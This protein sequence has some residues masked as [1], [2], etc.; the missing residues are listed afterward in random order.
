MK[1]I[2]ISLL[3]IAALACFVGAWIAN[4]RLTRD[5]DRRGLEYGCKRWPHETNND[6]YQRLRA[7]IGW[8]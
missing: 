2:V 6:Y 8:S 3:G 7:R 5:L 4:R 1:I